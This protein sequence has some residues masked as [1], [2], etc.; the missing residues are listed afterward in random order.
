MGKRSRRR[1]QEKQQKLHPHVHN[2]AGRPVGAGPDAVRARCPTCGGHVWTQGK[3]SSVPKKSTAKPTSLIPVDQQD[4]WKNL[5]P[6]QPDIVKARISQR[7]GKRTVVMVGTS[8]DNAGQT[9]WDEPGIEAFWSL[10]DAHHL[11]FMHMDRVTA[12]F[13]LHHRWRFTRRMPRYKI[14]HWAWLQEKHDFPV[15]MQKKYDDVPSSAVYPLK[16]ITE[17]YLSGMIGR[18]GFFQRKY[19]TCSFPYLI[20]LAMYLGFQRIEMYGIQLAQQIEYIMQRPCTEFWCGIAIGQ[21][22]QLYT[23]NNCNI[24]A[25]AMYGYRWPNLES[26][27]QTGEQIGIFPEEE[28]L[29][30]NWD[31]PEPYIDRFLMPILEYPPA[32]DDVMENPAEGDSAAPSGG[33]ESEIESGGVEEAQREAVAA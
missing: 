10:N 6:E 29:V 2:D 28:D 21:G 14:D 26:A 13:Q 5:P 20:G 4:L 11:P 19:Y 7:L 18:G 23:P 12:W 1:W 8:P 25:G 16:E 9:P 3:G 22:I 15:F 17:R 30:G 32:T 33:V 24:M 27:K 31:E